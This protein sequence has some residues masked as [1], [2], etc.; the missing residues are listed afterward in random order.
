M[1]EE[2]LAFLIE[3]KARTIYHSRFDMG[4]HNAFLPNIRIEAQGIK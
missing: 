4:Q 2:K 1:D 3:K